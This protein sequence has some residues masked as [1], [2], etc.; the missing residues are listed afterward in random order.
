[1]TDPHDLSYDPHETSGD[2][3]GPEPPSSGGR[4]ARWIVLLVLLLALVGAGVWY[5]FL[6]APQEP[7]PAPEPVAQSAAEPAREPAEVRPEPPEIELPPLSASDELVR[8][9]VGELSSHPRVAAFLADEELVRRFVA[10]VD[11][12]ARG[13]SP[14]PHLAAAAPDGGFPVL[15]ENG[16]VLA[17]PRGYDRYDPLVAAFTGLDPEGSAE[18]Y[19]RLEPLIDQAYRELGYPDRE[20]DRTL[21]RAIAELLAVPVVEGPVELVP[22]VQRYEYADPRLEDLSAAQKHLLRAGPDNVRRVQNHLRALAAALGLE[23]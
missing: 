18:T 20:F 3:G 13:T 15:E 10:T 22:E 8:R 23:V 14:R 17:D 6:R 7:A 21:E 4:R 16:R 19:R 12:V 2:A 9:L 5:L 11:N 1:M